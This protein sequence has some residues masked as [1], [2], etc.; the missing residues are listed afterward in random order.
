MDDLQEKYNELD[1]I[2]STLRILIDG[3]TNED[4]IYQLQ[5]IMYQA[6][7]EKD[8]IEPELQEIYAREDNEMNY[9]YERSVI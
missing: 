6:Q 1:E 5:E 7:N 2:E 9:Q 3:I 8:E 4:Y